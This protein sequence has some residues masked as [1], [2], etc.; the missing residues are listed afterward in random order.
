MASFFF[1][2]LFSLLSRGNVCQ[3]KVCILIGQLNK[4]VLFLKVKRVGG[5]ET[6]HAN[7]TELKKEIRSSKIRHFQMQDQR[8]AVSANNCLPLL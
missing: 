7:N 5:D 1:F 8:S 4:A 3:S 6:R 2:F